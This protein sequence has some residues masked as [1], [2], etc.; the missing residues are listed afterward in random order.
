MPSARIHEAIARNINKKYNMDDILLR[1]GTISP[2]CWRNVP[3]DSGIKD[4]KLSHFW[5]FRIKQGQANDYLEFYLK[6]YN[7]ITNP[8]Y[9]GYLIHLIVDQYWKSKIDQNYEMEKNG[10]SYVKL[11]NG[12]WIKDENW[13]SYYE[14]LKMQRQL[15]KIYDLGQ[16][17]TSINDIPNFKC[18]ID[19][20]NLNGLFGEEGSI[21]YVNKNLMPSDDEE[22]VVY[23]NKSIIKAISDTTEFVLNEL[24]N[25]KHMKKKYDKK[26]KIAIDID[27]TLIC[28]KELEEYFWKKFLN[29][30]PEIDS[31][32]EYVW[33][34]KELQLFW[35]EYRENMAFGKI[36]DNASKT[37]E[38]LNSDG[39]IVDL[40]TA[41]PLSKY[42][43]LKQ[44]LMNHF[45]ENSV[46]YNHLYLGF[47][48]KDKFLKEHNYDI[49]IDDNLKNINEANLSGI[50][51]ILFGLKIQIIMD[52]KLII[53]V[54]YQ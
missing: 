33:G 26:I 14:G 8:F 9:F 52:I 29:E 17:P 18:E 53:G 30:H 13:F 38:K 2:D 3:K 54:K 16:L 15:A 20:L 47:Y 37:L 49:L 27:D 36:K 24:E 31:Q 22:S 34:D 21:S 44:K 46:K 4:K 40:L 50:N 6:Y 51:T 43:S 39:Y 12:N 11:N 1:I 42:A 7:D 35:N 28:T 10:I 5:D 45:E 41:R 48:K 32:K 19:E 25:L 23:D